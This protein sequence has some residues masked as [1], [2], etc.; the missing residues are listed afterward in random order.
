VLAS[1]R[2]DLVARRRTNTT[3]RLAWATASLLLALNAIP[4]LAEETPAPPIRQMD[5][6]TKAKVLAALAGLI[7][8]GF[9]MVA[10]IWLGAR[11]AQR[12]R[13]GSSFFRPTPRPGEHDW[14]RKPLD[15]E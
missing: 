5:G 2:I 15:E 9:G 4:S 3:G 10:L 14:A 8:L 12:Y 1:V 13:Q 7:I 6:A 11:V